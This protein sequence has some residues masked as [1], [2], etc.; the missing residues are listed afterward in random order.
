MIKPSR[1]T[2]LQ[3]GLTVV[4]IMIAMVVGLVLLAGVIQLFLS[5]KQNYRVQEGLSRLQENG[6]YAMD[7]AVL[8]LRQAGYKA[9]GL[10]ADETAFA[11]DNSGYAPAN[12]NFPTAGQIVTGADNN[13]SG[14]DLVLDGTDTISFRLQAPDD[15]LD[16]SEFWDCLVLLGPEEV[17]VN[18]LYV[19]APEQELHCRSEAGGDD[20]QPLLDGV[21]DMQVQYGV[22]TDSDGIANMYGTA[23]DVTSAGEWTRVVSVRIALLLNTV[24]G[25]TNDP[26][27]SIYNLLGTTVGPFNDRLRRHVFT[28][29]VALRNQLQ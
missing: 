3:S 22:D 13:T 23:T 11:V 26:D 6:R 17:A 24:G 20:D 19:K 5:N 8:N 14:V 16:D 27:T 12:A 7:V 15:A 21:Q 25:I 28:T 10:T 1:C 18:T 2:V 4:E 29:T 9:H